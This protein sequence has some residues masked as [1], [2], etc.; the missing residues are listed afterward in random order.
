MKTTTTK[1]YKLL[2]LMNVRLNML[3]KAMD[4]TGMTKSLSDVD[5]G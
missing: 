5:A 3:I 1:N 4:G 2:K